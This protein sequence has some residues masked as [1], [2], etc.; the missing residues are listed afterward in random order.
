MGF[1][2]ACF[3]GSTVGSRGLWVSDDFD[4]EGSSP[5]WRVIDEGLYYGGS[6][7]APN[8]M[9]VNPDD[10]YRM[11]FLNCGSKIYKRDTTEGDGFRLVLTMQDA[12]DLVGAGPYDP[13]WYP[14]LTWITSDPTISG[15][16]YTV[17]SYTH[18]D[19][20]WWKPTWAA[21]WPGGYVIATDDY[22][23]TWYGFA[24]LVSPNPTLGVS[25]PLRGATEVSA[26]AG[27]V[28]TAVS[29]PLLYGEGAVTY[30]AGPTG[31]PGFPSRIMGGISKYITHV[32]VNPHEPDFSYS[33]ALIDSAY[34]YGMWKISN[35]LGGET[36]YVS[37]SFV[38][39]GHLLF[40]VSDHQSSD[41]HWI[42]PADN[43]DHILIGLGGKLY[44]SGSD[45]IFSGDEV[46][47]NPLASAGNIQ[48][49][50]SDDYRSLYY[51]T[52]GRIWGLDSR[53]SR[54]PINLSASGMNGLIANYG[55]YVDPGPPG[56]RG[57]PYVFSIELGDNGADDTSSS[58][59]RLM[60]SDSAFNTI[61]QPELHGRD[62]KELT[63]TVHNPWPANAGDAPVSDGSKYV[64]TP[65]L[66]SFGQIILFR[67]GGVRGEIYE[68]S[69]TGMEN[70]LYDAV[71]GD[72]IV[73]SGAG[74]LSGSF[75]LG[76]NIEC[77]GS[78]SAI[79]TSPVYMS[80]SSTLSGFSIFVT[81][82][83][84]DSVFGISGP[85]YST[86]RIIECDIQVRQS[87]SGNA[88]GISVHTGGGVIAEDCVVTGI[89][90]YG[91]G[92]AGRS[93]SGTLEVHGGKYSGSTDW[94]YIQ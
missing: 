11:Q 36:K 28:W 4:I 44:F 18:G 68:F 63:P 30:V 1:A 87:G 56:V 84:S 76:E 82:D 5:T 42:N 33:G 59:R 26:Y 27:R 54:I 49:I 86:A 80:A 38:A 9:C 77:V 61:Q 90:I 3:N 14:A 75:I 57:H 7:V 35:A 24:P 94:F 34:S 21:L 70:A 41:R 65:V 23:E 22:G 55:L 45:L 32:K 43:E 48:A 39:S 53:E 64:P 88:F 15:R 92:Y 6:F 79:L 62:I 46:S 52:A 72:K 20:A 73:V 12:I 69:G 31:D 67:E 29:L 10:P 60:G 16:Y 17:Y 93:I 89:S 66:T 85:N 78:K 8:T 13:P 47:I 83:S 40:Q 25:T 71:S 51:T 19:A 50:A 58:G 37:K 74:E 81:A 2:L 91:D